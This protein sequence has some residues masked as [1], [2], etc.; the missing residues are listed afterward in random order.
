[1]KNVLLLF[2]IS[3]SN[4]FNA[5]NIIDDKGRKQGNW[6]KKNPQSNAIDY[7]GQFK[8]DK[9]VVTFIY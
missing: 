5:Q 4:F 1:M 2:I 3:F 8:D 9:T 6:I 7:T